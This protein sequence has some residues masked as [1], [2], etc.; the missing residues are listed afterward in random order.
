M[1]STAGRHAA[2]LAGIALTSPA[3][4]DTLR[5]A[6]VQAYRTSPTL[7]AAQAT[8]RALDENVPIARAAGLPSLAATGGIVDN[9]YGTSNSLASPVRQTTGSSTLTVPVFSGGQVRNSVRAAETRVEAGQIGLR[10]TESALFTAVVGA[11][12]D[13][14][15]DEAIVSLN[16][17]NV[18]V[19]EVNL[20]A[21]RD[22]FQVGDL[23]RTDVAQ[24]D[25][26][27]ALARAQLQTAQATLIS[28]RENYIRV[29]G[30][31]PG[32]LEQP[33]ALPAF[34][35]TP[36]AAVEIAL[37]E[38]P[39]L[40]AYQ[41][42]RDATRYD[43]AAARAQ[44]MPRLNVVV[45][46]N[47]YNYLGSLGAGTGVRVGQ[48]AFGG[49]VGASVNVPI[50]SGGAVSAGIR[51]AEA[52][53][54]AATEQATD[55]GRSVVD[56]TRAAYAVWRSSQEVIQSSQQA[57]SAN[58]LSLQGVR[59]ENSVGN[60]TILDILNAEQELLNS[61][62]TLVTAQRDA[63]VA[64]FALL[65]SMGQAQAKTLGLD[66]GALYDPVAHYKDVRRRIFGTGQGERGQPVGTSTTRTPAQG[67]EPSRPLDPSLDTPVDRDGRLT[68]GEHAPSR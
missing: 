6:M 8:Q 20:K 35:A 57:V 41:K 27:L 15:R 17:R 63:Y 60:R 3:A 32:V 30:A 5:Q 9:P 65:A 1:T 22:R 40:L 25:A 43:I 58:R 29:V 36:D 64:G 4:A 13:V 19:L 2:L 21:T 46:G 61:Q 49:T 52:R 44:R 66:G 39:T 14:I 42:Q 31:P 37:R 26:R 47:Y 56:Q 10:G 62:V 50:F 53:R 45:G 28:S 55:A 24:S 33:P 54:S 38:N 18:H 51:Q 12:M 34:P 23:T 48:D 11:Y 16:G 67:S 7:T 59:A 68:T